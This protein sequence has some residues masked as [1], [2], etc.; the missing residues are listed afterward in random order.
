MPTPSKWHRQRDGSARACLLILG[1]LSTVSAAPGRLGPFHPRALQTFVSTRCN[2]F[3]AGQKDINGGGGG[4]S[5]WSYEGSLVD[6]TNG[7]I[8]AEVEGVELCRHLSELRNMNIK[9]PTQ[10]DP[11]DQGGR[12]IQLRSMTRGLKRMG[13]LKARDMLLAARDDPQKDWDYA[14]TVLSRR[15]FVYR[16]PP[17]EQLTESTKENNPGHPSSFR[18]PPSL[19]RSIRFRPNSPEKRLDLTDTMA[20]YDTATTYISRNRGRSMS[21]L[22]EFADG[23]WVMGST[24]AAANDGSESDERND[25]NAFDYCVYARMGGGSGGVTKTAKNMPSLVPIRVG[26]E[27]SSEKGNNKGGSSTG[28]VVIS[29]PRSKFVQFGKDNSVERARYG[30]RETYS[31]EHLA[32]IGND[33]A[34]SG[35]SNFVGRMANRA[36]DFLPFPSPQSTSPPPIVRYTRYGESPPWYR[37]SQPATLELRG[38]RIESFDDA[39]PLISSL[40]ARYV[41]GLLNVDFPIPSG[42]DASVICRS[43]RMGKREGAMQPLQKLQ[44]EADASAIRAVDWFRNPSSNGGEVMTLLDENNDLEDQQDDPFTNASNFQTM[45]RKMERMGRKATKNGA[46]IAGR[47]WDATAVSSAS[48]APS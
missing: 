40:A 9:S 29:P 24:D 7:R 14:T 33:E 1:I 19:L 36:R 48:S 6:P 25:I 10:D 2:V 47:V 11:A 38:K 18:L 12:M 44:D 8:V 17:A 13:N 41:P 26:M 30:A 3:H 42:P 21:I 34:K 23:H 15:M 32:P 37:P 45:R 31:F 27:M 46:A 22:T 39:P 16:A 28:S 4:S 20:V 35:G 5:V 43:R